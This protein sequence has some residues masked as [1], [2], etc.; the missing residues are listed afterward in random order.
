MNH[1]A[2]F[3]VQGVPV[4]K[5][6]ARVVHR[7]RFVR[8]YSPG[9]QTKYES[10]VRECYKGT[11]NTSLPL[12]VEILSVLP[13]PK[14]FSKKKRAE[15]L[16]CNILPTS[17]PDTDNIAKSVMDALNGFAYKDDRQVVSVLSIK[18][19]GDNPGAYVVINEADTNNF[20]KAI[21]L[22]VPK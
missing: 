22:I 5:M 16:C 17:K 15:C 12:S 19:Y 7:G 18:V 11:K 3:F 10:H 4:G 1:I 6:R 14:S 13:I 8:E 2:S 21:D 9:K 20:K